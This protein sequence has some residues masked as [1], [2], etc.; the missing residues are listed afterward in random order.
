MDMKETRTRVDALLYL[1]FPHTFY[2]HTDSSA[3]AL[4]VLVKLSTVRIVA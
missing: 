4:Q 2:L 3:D 1:N